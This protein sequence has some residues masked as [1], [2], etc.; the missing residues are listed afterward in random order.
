MQEERKTAKARGTLQYNLHLWL[1]AG[2][3]G[4][5]AGLEEESRFGAKRDTHCI[6]MILA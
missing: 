5:V 6:V 4:C 3:N 1:A 2:M